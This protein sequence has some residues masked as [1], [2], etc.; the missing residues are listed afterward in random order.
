MLG[1]VPAECLVFEDSAA[2]IWAAHTAGMPVVA[3][4]TTLSPAR[5]AEVHDGMVIA[6]FT[7]V[8]YDTIKKLQ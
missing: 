3:L 8:G 5:I 2:G 7:E 4:S 6:D 1:V